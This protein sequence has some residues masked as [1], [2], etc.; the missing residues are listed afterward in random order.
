M[1]LFNVDFGLGLWLMPDEK[2]Q[3][4]L[5]PVIERLARRF[6][7]PLFPAHIT[8]ATQLKT[9]AREIEALLRSR[10][11]SFKKLFVQFSRAHGKNQFFQA[12]FLEA[13]LE[14][15]LQKLRQEFVS[16]TNPQEKYYPHL[17]LYYGRLSKADFEKALDSLSFEFPL[18]L[19]FD[20]LALY[21]I[22]GPCSNWS[23]IA[24]FPLT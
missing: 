8:V 4:A 15:P 23:K 5:S 10:P 11:S 22:K 17:S 19:Y 18:Q 20:H 12:L 7:G 13:A 14:Q 1:S 9:S 21:Q 3:S 16:Q 24:D 2:E 6:D